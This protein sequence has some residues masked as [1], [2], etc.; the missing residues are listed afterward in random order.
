MKVY[1]KEMYSKQESIK[2]IIVFIIVFLL[3]FFAGYMAHSFNENHEDFFS[4]TVTSADTVDPVGA[5]LTSLVRYEYPL[6]SAFSM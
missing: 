6:S 5:C 3:G 1:D 2:T 4:F